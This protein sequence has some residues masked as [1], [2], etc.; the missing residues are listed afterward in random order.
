MTDKYTDYSKL[1]TNAESDSVSNENINKT[2][3]DAVTPALDLTAVTG[4]DDTVP[5][6]SD[7]DQEGVLDEN[8]SSDVESIVRHGVVSN[9]VALNVRSKPSAAGD[10][11]SV[12]VAGTAVDIDVSNSDRYYY[13]VSAILENSIENSDPIIVDGFCSKG[14]I[15]V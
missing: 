5:Q 10:V 14:Y 3:A 15:T 12:L 11:V 6:F 7:P 1:S 2:D 8:L 9:C 4:E 13:K